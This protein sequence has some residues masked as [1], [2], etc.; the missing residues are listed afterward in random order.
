MHKLAVSGEGDEWVPHSYAPIFAVEATSA[1]TRRLVA[2]VPGGDVVVLHKLMECLVA[3]FFL[4]Y[5]L[6]TPRGEGK[7]GRYQSPLLQD[8]E[9]R[10]FLSCYAAFFQGDAR[11]DIW[12]HSPSSNGTLVWDRHDLI[13]G[14]GPVECF[15][16]GL[17]EIGFSEGMLYVPGPHQHFYREECDADAAKILSEFSWKYFPLHPEDEQ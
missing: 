9:L 14:Y 12:V 2:G 4:L 6:H 11:F 8:A 1:R 10:A 5:V 13:Y 16:A 3:P 17:Q 15:A 7:P